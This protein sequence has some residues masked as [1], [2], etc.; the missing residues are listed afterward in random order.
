MFRSLR[1][2]LAFNLKRLSPSAG[3]VQDDEAEYDAP[4]T[5]ASI[6]SALESH[7]HVVVDLE[8]DASFP[9]T[10]L[11]SGVDVVF[12]VA[13]GAH[14]RSR[15]AHVPSLLELLRVPYTGSDPTCM[16][17]TLDKQLA[18]SVVQKAGVRTPP[19]VVMTT[20]DEPLPPDMRLP[21]IVK[22]VA[23]GSSK[24][25]L[26]SSVATTESELRALAREMA[27]R[28]R[29]GALVEEYLP[30]REFTV[31]ILG[32][33]KPTVLAPMEVVFTTDDEHPVY[34]F[35]HKLE[36]TSEVRYEVP[37]KIGSELQREIIDLAE[38]AFAALGCRDVA[39]IDVR[40]DRDGHASFIECNP[41][42]GLTPGWSDL[43]LI[44]E[45]AGIDYP[46][47]IG[48]ILQPA[49]DRLPMRRAGA[50]MPPPVDTGVQAAL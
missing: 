35:D 8:A 39:R 16:V 49:I 25:V 50:T 4:S 28:Y 10:L 42:P 17:L 7:G 5:I 2:G 21:A 36:P 9:S 43:C 30:G 23:E 1:V 14:G 40:I 48:R 31:G 47:L 41:L 13:E 34:S 26:P 24:G 20:G 22:P 6:R 44:A 11:A 37:A 27:G 38:R 12:N 3:C 29:Q 18:K 32:G 45:A 46:T 15:E 19:S 33:P